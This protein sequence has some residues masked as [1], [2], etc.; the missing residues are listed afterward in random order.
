MLE[1]F[2]DFLNEQEKMIV[3]KPEEGSNGMELIVTKTVDGGILIMATKDKKSI[4]ID[5][6][7]FDRLKKL[8]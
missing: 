7:L 4:Y 2:E 6:S 5:P 1:K 8:M 3:L